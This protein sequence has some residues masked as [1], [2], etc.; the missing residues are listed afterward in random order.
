MTAT[1]GT[2]SDF[3]SVWSPYLYIALAVAVVVLGTLLW[4]V[5]RYRA[6]GGSSSSRARPSW[7][8]RLEAGW[9]VLVAAVVAILLTLTFRSQERIAALGSDPPAATIRVTAFQWGWRFD[10]GSGV[11]ET[12][13]NRR[14]PV[15]VVPE[16]VLVRFTL[17][18][19]DVIHSFWIPEERF[20]RDAMPGRVTDFGL[21]FDSIA[22]T[23]RCAEYCG[24]YHSKM[25]FHVEPIPRDQFIRWLDL[26][27]AE[28]RDGRS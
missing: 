12:G 9:I 24:L 23:G 16:G 14:T 25:D 6:G 5:L 2:R 22:S 1:G 19:R 11:V 4:V 17:T 27:R 15:L 8:K 28:V 18:S 13:N 21:V 20:K 26:Q 3:G 7:L 10:Y